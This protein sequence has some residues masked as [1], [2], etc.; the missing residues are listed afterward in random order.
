MSQ[1]WRFYLPGD[2]RVFGYLIPATVSQMPWT[3]EFKLDE[4]SQTVSL[5]PEDGIDLAASSAA[6]MAR[7][8]KAAQ[9]LGSFPKL[10]NWPG[11]KFPVL[12]APFPFAVDR[13][14]SPYLSTGSQLTV[15][16]CAE[17]GSVAGIWVAR[18][19]TDKPTYA[20][21]L[22]N[23][24]GGAVKHSEMPFECILRE[25]SEELRI[26]AA[27]AVPGGAIS[28]FSIK[29]PRAGIGPGL[30]EPG[31]QYVYDVEADAKSVPK[32]ELIG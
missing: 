8:L 23:A 7:L 21:M 2:N 27:A 18:R 10:S 31:V 20:S 12:G 14:I 25:A 19:A 30:L 3:S 26:D 24:V 6:A 9:D 5:E 1:L 16:V 17:N 29:G 11:E 15:F 13:A 22:D 4:S 32:Q 28:W